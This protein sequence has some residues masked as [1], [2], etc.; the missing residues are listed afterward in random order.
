VSATA[1]TALTTLAGFG[2][3]YAAA[4]LLLACASLRPARPQ[5][6]P[7]VLLARAVAPTLVASIVSTALILPAFLLFE[8]AHDGERA[9]VVLTALAVLGGAQIGAAAVRAIRMLRFARTVTSAW[10]VHARPLPHEPWGLPAYAVD[11][12]FPVVAVAG[13]FRPRLFVDRRVLTVCSPAELA[14]I[15]AHERAHVECRD[16]LRRLLVGA[17]EGPRSRAAAAWRHA[18]E[19]AADARAAE[20]SERAVD[21]A[22]ALVK[23]AR[24]APGRPLETAA[25]STIH[26][27]GSL[28][29]RIQR[30]LAVDRPAAVRAPRSVIWLAAAPA[31]FAILLQGRAM[32]AWTHAAVELLVRYLP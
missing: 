13:F 8:P 2:L 11:A 18:A 4:R 27:G 22:A 25:L 9:G 21:L 30:L 6:R 7:A 28:E 1:M 29:A 32:L 20:S 3:A 10:G 26:D 19:H 12:G 23:I 15:A 16:N 5:A 17:C 24:L 14:A 31:A